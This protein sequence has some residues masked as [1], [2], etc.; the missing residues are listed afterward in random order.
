MKRLIILGVFIGMTLVNIAVFFIFG[1][2]F[3][4]PNE[5]SLYKTLDFGRQYDV[6]LDIEYL[7]SNFEPA[8]E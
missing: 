6:K 7:R 8:H 3:S 5:T 4:V 1:K 2:A